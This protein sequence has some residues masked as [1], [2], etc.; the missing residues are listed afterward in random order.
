MK[1][2]EAID[3]IFSLASGCGVKAVE[4]LPYH[5]LGK[6]KYVQLGRTYPM[7]DMPP[8]DKTELRGYADLGAK[9][10]ITVTIR[11]GAA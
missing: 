11:D 1:R 5:I 2:P 9:R 6:S 8:L 10:N 7:G 3:G 4:L